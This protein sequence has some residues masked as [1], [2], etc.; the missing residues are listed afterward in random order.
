MTDRP[1]ASDWGDLPTASQFRAA[2]ALLG[3]N[4]LAISQNCGLSN[5]EVHG[6]E[7]GEVIYKGKIAQLRDYY[8][9]HGV[10][11][12]AG[13][14]RPILRP[15]PPGFRHLCGPFY[16]VL[17]ESGLRAANRH[18]T[19]RVVHCEGNEKIAAKIW[20]ESPSWD[21]HVDLPDVAFPALGIFEEI[22]GATEFSCIELGVFRD[23]LAAYTK[24]EEAGP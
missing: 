19:L 22:H 18:D 5:K 17:D 16:I 8:Q 13:G 3:R 10:G 15:L 6:I 24:N 2:R 21:L 9:T 14:V 4:R 1:V 23:A 11:F 20:D 12:E 7:V